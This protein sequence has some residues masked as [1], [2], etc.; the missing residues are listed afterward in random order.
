MSKKPISYASRD[1]ET[2]K[3]SLTNYAKR[4][5]PS[6]FKDFN[7]ASF[8]ALMLDLVSYIGDELSF[9]TD[10]QANESFLDSAMEYDNVIR[11]SQQLGYK[12]P[13]A[14]TTTGTIT[15]YILIPAS[16]S[17]GEP[18]TNYLPILQRGLTL[19]SDSGAIYT[20][21]ENVDFAAANNE[22]T[23][24]KVDPDTGVPTWFAVQAFGTVVSG[25]NGTKTLSTGNYQRFLRLPLGV[26]NVSEIISV[27]DSQ[28]NEYS[29]VENLTQDVVVQEVPN[30][31]STRTAVPYIM[32]L[33]PV[34]RRF[35]VEYDSNGDAF[36]QF[37]YGSAANLTGDVIADPSDVVLDVVGRDYISDPSFDPSNLIKTDK[38]GVVPENTTLTV[39]YRSNTDS[40]INSAVGA[41]TS[42]LNPELIFRNESNLVGATIDEVLRS[43][44]AENGEPITGDTSLLMPDEV[45]TRAYGTYASQ[46]RAVTRSDYINVAYRMPA[47]FGRV[48]RANVVQDKDSVKRNLNMYVLSENTNGNFS[49]ANQ[50][51]K[52]NL[53][54]WINRYRMM[55]DTIDILDSTVINYGIEFEI[56][57]ELDVN[58]YELLDA[59]TN[60]IKDKLL[61]VKKNIGEAV[62]I[63]EIYKLLNEVPGVIDTMNVE[64]VN[65]TGGLY[66]SAEYDIDTNLSNDGRY[67]IIPQDSVAEV[68]LPDI[69]VVGVV[70]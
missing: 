56:S 51:L 64:L 61:N 13:G 63:S 55:N 46:N 57:A 16:T 34:P 32:R 17:T 62:Y 26:G 28:G 14:V 43:L 18:N 19:S 8:G 59:C 41:V 58:K 49:P 29:E 5:Y 45:R 42:I 33:K 24:A 4:Y 68:L 27:V 12:V 9:Y 31:E 52:E 65:K 48:K 44:E 30:Y 66:S 6:T 25:Q 7:E 3:Q 11:L 35:V 10:Y 50:T 22:I 40:N 23:V 39:T 60:K 37:G 67:L 36:L 2:I 47:K 38:F 53:R 54:T 1:F 69:D 15:F 70:K 20:L 21:N